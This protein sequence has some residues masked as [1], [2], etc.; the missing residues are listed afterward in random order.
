MGFID[1][2]YIA[3]AALQKKKCKPEKRHEEQSRMHTRVEHI[4]TCPK[5]QN[6]LSIKS[7]LQPQTIQN[8]RRRD[9]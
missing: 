9:V 5:T 8:S 1:Y 6:P 3:H 7:S 2:V 4:S